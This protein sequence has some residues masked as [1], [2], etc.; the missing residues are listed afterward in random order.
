[1]KPIKA[2]L[3]QTVVPNK[4][5]IGLRAFSAIFAGYLLAATVSAWVALVLPLSP[6]ENTL[7]AMML[8]FIVYA[9]AGLWAFS[10]QTHWR[11]L[12]DLVLLSGIFYLFILVIG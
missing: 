6:L 10:V 11:A 3:L 1:M 8:S 7:T 2:K 4:F 5:N 9:F 12:S